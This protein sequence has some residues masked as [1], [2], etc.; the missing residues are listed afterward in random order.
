VDL[1]VRRDSPRAPTARTEAERRGDPWINLNIHAGLLQMLGNDGGEFYFV[2]DYD[3]EGARFG[4]HRQERVTGMFL[5]FTGQL[6]K[7]T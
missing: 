4:A 5:Q 2:F 6:S 1:G 3:D 7:P